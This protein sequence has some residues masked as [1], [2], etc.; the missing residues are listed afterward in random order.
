MNQISAN[1]A[2]VCSKLTNGKFPGITDTYVTENEP[3]VHVASKLVGLLLS[4][5]RAEIKNNILHP[6]KLHWKP[7]ALS[8]ILFLSSSVVYLHHMAVACF[9]F[10]L[11]A[12]SHLC[13]WVVFS[14]G[15]A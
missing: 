9:L 5:G 3:M 13:M 12:K 2:V 7:L 4:P 14:V 6:S 15:K 8:L 10:R 11:V 1:A